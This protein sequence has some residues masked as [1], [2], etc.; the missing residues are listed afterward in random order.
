MCGIQ[1]R[2]ELCVLLSVGSL[3]L[4]GLV[5]PMFAKATGEFS[6]S[7]RPGVV[8]A[9]TGAIGCTWAFLYCPG[10]FVP[11]KLLTLVLMLA[12]LLI[13]IL[14]V[15]SYWKWFIWEHFM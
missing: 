12:G 1:K 10:R 5:L 9:L 14:E 15:L 2:W 11:A 4:D 6:N 13:G 8:A 3:V 7:G